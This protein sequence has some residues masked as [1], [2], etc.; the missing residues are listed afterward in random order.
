[1]YEGHDQIVERPGDDDAVVDVE[2]EH[3]RHC[4]VANTLG[5]TMM[6]MMGVV[7]KGVVMMMM[8][9]MVRMMTMMM[10]LRHYYGE[11]FV[12][13]TAERHLSIT[14]AFASHPKEARCTGL[15]LK[16]ISNYEISKKNCK[17]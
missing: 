16:M 14:A 4:R 15:Q 13:K 10:M 3:N 11:T 6:M 1:M 12:I 9:V 5:L 2:P 8:M 17:V 7:V